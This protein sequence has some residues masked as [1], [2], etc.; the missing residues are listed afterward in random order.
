[1]CSKQ[2]FPCVS[3][4]K[5][6]KFSLNR[7]VKGSYYWTRVTYLLSTFVLYAAVLSKSRSGRGRLWG[8]RGAP[9]YRAC[10]WVS[11]GH[12][13]KGTGYNPCFSK[14]RQ[15]IYFF[16]SIFRFWFALRM[17]NLFKASLLKGSKCKKQHF[18]ATG[19]RGTEGSNPSTC[20]YQEKGLCFTP[21]GFASAVDLL[22]IYL[23]AEDTYSKT[24]PEPI[25]NLTRFQPKV[26]L[27]C[28]ALATHWQKTNQAWESFSKEIIPVSSVKVDGKIICLFP[29]GWG[30]GEGGMDIPT[31]SH[32]A[33]LAPKWADLEETSGCAGMPLYFIAGLFL[34]VPASHPSGNQEWTGIHIQSSKLRNTCSS[35]SL[36]YMVLRTASSLKFDCVPWS[37]LGQLIFTFAF[38][39]QLSDKPPFLLQSSPPAFFPDSFSQLSA[40]TLT[41]SVLGFQDSTCR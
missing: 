3:A 31:P 29:P 14:S 22:T 37:F 28:L 2:T 11:R 16:S 13:L 7:V 32:P 41:A 35:H 39:F 23:K 10:L 40:M 20:H 30:A 33:V 38:L 8:G 36:S 9:G 26:C 15:P 24:G 6:K 18:K 5:G 34:R 27:C 12:Q 19:Q 4:G 17:Q 21:N 1:M 25:T